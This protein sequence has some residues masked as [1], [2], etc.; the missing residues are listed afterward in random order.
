MVG[1][2]TW[3]VVQETE[4]HCHEI[5]RNAEQLF[6]IYQGAD[7][8]ILCHKNIFGPGGVKDHEE[9]RGTWMQDSSGLKHL[10]VKSKL[11]RPR[12]EGTS[13]YAAA[14]AHLSNSTAKK[15]DVAKQLLSAGKLRRKMVQ[16][17]L[18][19]ISTPRLTENAERSGVSSFDEAWKEAFSVPSARRCSVVGPNEGNRRLLQLHFE[20]KKKFFLAICESRELPTQQS[21]DAD[22]GKRPSDAPSRV[23]TPLPSTESRAKHSQWGRQAVQQAT[24]NRKTS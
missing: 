22:N 1:P 24:W 9:V 21:Q 20:K 8:L 2:S 15:R 14:S 3:S 19:A 12:K 4:T 17:S 23:R 7:Q 16:I 5:A 11:R 6:H 13:T 10:V 18:R